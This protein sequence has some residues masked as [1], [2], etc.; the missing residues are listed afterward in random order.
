MELEDERET[1]LGLLEKLSLRGASGVRADLGGGQLRASRPRKRLFL[2]FVMD[3]DYLAA[4]TKYTPAYLGQP[5]MDRLQTAGPRSRRSSM[6]EARCV[7]MLGTRLLG[8][9]YI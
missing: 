3:M 2:F 6:A 9:F 4:C 7:A 8:G 1:M 5:F